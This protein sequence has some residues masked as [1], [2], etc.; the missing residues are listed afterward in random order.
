MILF[1]VTIMPLCLVMWAVTRGEKKY[2]ISALT[3]FLSGAL[4]CAFKGFLTFSH[5]IVP[6]SFSQNFFYLF[7]FE[8]FLPVAILTVI[9][10]LLSHD[11]IEFKTKSFFPLNCAF[12]IT[13]LPYIILTGN[14]A[15]H[16][17]FELF[18]KPLLLVEALF[19]IGSA[20]VEFANRLK[21]SPKTCP[22]PV[23][24]ALAAIVL[25]S[26]TESAFIMNIGNVWYILG[27][28][29]L[30]GLC[31]IQIA[32]NFIKNSPKKMLDKE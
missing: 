16:T 11:G 12:Y 4:V 8:M 32:R 6:Y 2:F 28:L 21:S 27:T 9:F 10:F 30:T 5:R 7:F 29:A 25:P 18:I 20:L 24:P 17:H 26:L 22:I 23:L 13:F 3:G 31:A 15:I 14:K 19:L 1:S